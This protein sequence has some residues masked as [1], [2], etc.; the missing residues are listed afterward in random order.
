MYL[1][2]TA[3][4]FTCYPLKIKTGSRLITKCAFGSFWS[5]QRVHLRWSCEQASAKTARKDLKSSAD[6][7]VGSIF[8][9]REKNATAMGVK[10]LTFGDVSAGDKG[11]MWS[12]ETEKM[13]TASLQMNSGLDSSTETDLEG[14]AEIHAVLWVRIQNILNR[15]LPCSSGMQGSCT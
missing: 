14:R 5:N 6:N 15:L 10:G 13:P 11:S 7:L 2:S 1:C 4:N 3:V 12:T 8:S 9:I